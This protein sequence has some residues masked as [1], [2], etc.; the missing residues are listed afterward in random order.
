M[1]MTNQPL[2]T[3]IHRSVPVVLLI[4][5]L[6]GTQ[7][8][9]VKSIGIYLKDIS[10]SL[11]TTSKDIGVALGLFTAVCYLSGLGYCMV[12]LSAI[13]ILSQL[14][15]EQNFYLLYG[16]GTSGCGVGMVLLPLLAEHLDEFYGWRGG[17]LIQGCLMANLVP[18]AVAIK[19]H[20]T[21]SR[22][23]DQSANYQEL[24]HSGVSE[25]SLVNNC[26]SEE[27]D[28]TP[29]CPKGADHNQAAAGESSTYSS[30][31]NGIEMDSREYETSARQTFVRLRD[32]FYRSDFY[33]DP[34]FNFLFLASTML[35]I[36]YCGWHSFLVP[37]AIQRGYSI[38]ATI[39]V[40]FYASVG[41]FLGRLL[42]GALSGRLANPITLCLGAAFMSSLSIL[43]DA[44][45][46][47]YYMMI[48]SA[49]ISALSIGGM[50]VFNAL[51][52]KYRASPG[53]FDVAYTVNDVLFGLGTFLGGYL[54]GVVG[55]VFSYDATYKFL[56]GVQILV[57]VLMLPVA[58]FEKPT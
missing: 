22:P 29:L 36:V 34:V 41:N 11:G 17:I 12:G 32:S 49:C 38:R 9:T 26:S 1:D 50:C 43:C 20:V 53:S 28:S 58:V 57:F 37:H 15:S 30:L 55:G 51:S 6:S 47:N 42:G 45:F 48:V 27:E 40:T 2:R 31:V 54:S 33:R 25:E 39:L 46:R 8:G 4:F 3:A 56:G 21:G 18:C 23:V 14:T 10:H 5:L 35:G 7:V 44:F 24:E 52:V 19:L 13:L 16:F